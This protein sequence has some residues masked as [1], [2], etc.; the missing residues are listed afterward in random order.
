MSLGGLLPRTTVGVRLSD[1]PTSKEGLLMVRHVPGEEALNPLVSTPNADDQCLENFSQTLQEAIHRSLSQ[2]AVAND[3][4]HAV[5]RDVSSQIQPLL[6][7]LG[8][9]ENTAENIE[10]YLDTSPVYPQ[11]TGEAM[12]EMLLD[13]NNEDDSTTVN[14]SDTAIAMDDTAFSSH[15]PDMEPTVREPNT[16]DETESANPVRGDKEFPQSEEPSYTAAATVDERHGEPTLMSPETVSE[17]LLQ[18]K[19]VRHLAKG[20]YGYHS[21]L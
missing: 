10:M 11:D 2:H 17:L 6:D 1:F 21:L 15:Y 20:T 13:N 14:A 4:C 12:D 16:Q 5:S 7:T 18:M 3:V 8:R 19:F 9:P